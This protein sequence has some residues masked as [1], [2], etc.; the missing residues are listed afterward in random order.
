VLIKRFEDLTAWIESRAL[1]NG[2]YAIAK[3]PLARDFRL[4]DQIT[5]A[6]ISI[7]NNIAEG[8]DSSSST[9]FVRFLGYSRR[10]CSEV[11][12]CLYISLDQKYIDESTLKRLYESAEQIRKM[13]DG[14]ITRLEDHPWTRRSRTG[15]H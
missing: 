9:E 5:G 7:M 12:N 13:V 11:Q 4:R 10:S 2:V 6:A 15:Y 1:T 3:G 8:F 14:L